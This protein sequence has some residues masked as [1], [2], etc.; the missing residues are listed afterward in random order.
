M[1]GVAREIISNGNLVLK[2]QVAADDKVRPGALPR[3]LGAGEEA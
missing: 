1:T 2:A 3:M